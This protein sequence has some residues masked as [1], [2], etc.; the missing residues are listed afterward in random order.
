MVKQFERA[1]TSSTRSSGYRLS[2][3]EVVPVAWLPETARTNSYQEG[4]NVKFEVSGTLRKDTT[5]ERWPEPPHVAFANL[6]A[7]DP[8]AVEAF[9]RRYGILH[10]HRPSQ[11]FVEKESNVGTRDDILR[12]R[13]RNQQQM[14]TLIEKALHDSAGP[15]N[16]Q[17]SVE[18]FGVELD[19]DHLRGVWEDVESIEELEAQIATGIGIKQD[20]VE[21]WPDDLWALICLLAV[22]DYKAGRL[23]VCENPDCPAPYFRKKRTTQ[24]YCEQGPCVQYA[25]RQY[26][27]DWWNREGKKR[28]EKKSKVR[29]K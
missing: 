26:S 2:R 9:V 7:S 17:F 19:Q 10:W 5:E 1:K 22:R 25:Q 4:P 6:H 15:E 28:R 21:I 14:K 18:S 3:G 20:S 13:D 16:K 29:R 23:G 11:A 12:M 8:R 27:L 24:R